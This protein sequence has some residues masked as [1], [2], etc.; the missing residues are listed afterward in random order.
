M[1]QFNILQ[2]ILR[3]IEKAHRKNSNEHTVSVKEVILVIRDVLKVK[4]AI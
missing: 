4:E 3:K 2:T 1:E